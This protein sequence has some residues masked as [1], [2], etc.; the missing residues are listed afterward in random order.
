[1]GRPLGYGLLIGA[2]V[3]AALMLLWLLITP[4]NPG[5]VVL[6]LILMVVLAGPLAGAGYF[7]LNRARSE[8]TE[9]AAF[10]SRQRIIDTDRLFRRDLA[11]ELR[12]LARRPGLPAD[13]LSDLAD[14]VSRAAY[15]TPEWYASVDLDDADAATL[16]RYD[17]LVWERVRA[18][19]DGQ[20]DADQAV[21]ELERALDQRRTLLLRGSRA[22][23]AP[24]SDLLRADAPARPTAD[25]AAVAHGDAVTLDGTDYVVDG[26]TSAFAEGQTWKLARL[27]PSGAGAPRWLYVGPGG[28]ELAILDETADR[29]DTDLRL[30]ASGTATADVA[31]PAGSARGVLMRFERYRGPD[32]LAIVETWPDGRQHT[33]RGQGVRASDIEVWPASAR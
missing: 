23:I 14:D 31:G 22:P 30:E 17:D 13:R 21:R 12:Q 6:G 9:Q 20:S 24:P 16:R 15:D 32:H 8:A 10:T 27:V 25:P 7:V 33:Y 26:L 18:L 1:V 19:S 28:L 3:L 29:P 5:G 4:V 11:A 2:A